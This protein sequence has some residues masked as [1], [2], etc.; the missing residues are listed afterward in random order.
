MR[1]FTPA[2]KE[3]LKRVQG[4]L[5]DS[6][7][8]YADI[9]E[10]VTQLG[11][12]VTEEDV[13]TL[14]NG[15]KDEGVIR[16]FGATLKHQKAGYGANVMV[17]WKGAS[18]DEIMRVGP[19]LAESSAVSHCYY[20]KEAPGWPYHIYSMVHGSTKEQCLETVRELAEKTGLSEYATLFSIKELKKTSMTYF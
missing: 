13:L 2:E 19:I 3:I 15:L 5:P 11:H 20:R 1:E 17:A 4:S 14:L 10:Q 7:T 12:A 8:P 9:A 6:P 18:E 16:R